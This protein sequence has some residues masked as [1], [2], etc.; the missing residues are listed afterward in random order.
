[1]QG[2]MFGL[3]LRQTSKRRAPKSATDFDLRVA[4]LPHPEFARVA[5]TVLP[6]GK[7][8]RKNPPKRWI[9]SR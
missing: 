6:E 3:A 8:E 4:V 2:S 1:M 7:R 5:S 9:S